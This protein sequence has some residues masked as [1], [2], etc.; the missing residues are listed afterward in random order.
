MKKNKQSIHIF[1]RYD[2]LIFCECEVRI[3]FSDIIISGRTTAEKILL[4]ANKM[5]QP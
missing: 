1:T 2:I 5:M 3:W 4:E